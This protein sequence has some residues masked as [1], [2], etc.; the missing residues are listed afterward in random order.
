MEQVQLQYSPTESYED[1]GA[2]FSE[3]KKQA[4]KIRFTDISESQVNEWVDNG[5]LY[6]FQLYNKDYA[7]GAHGRKNLHTLYWENLFTD[8]N[9]SNLVLKLNGQ[10]ELFCRPQSIKKPV[11]HKIGSKMLN[12]RDKSGM[13]I[14]E[15]IYRS[16][17]QFYNGK[18]KESELTTA[19]KQYMDQ[20]I[21]K[22]VTHEIIKDRR[23]TRQEYFF[24]LPL[25]L[26]ANA[27][28]N[29]YI[30][31]QVL[32][33]LKDNPD[34]NIIGIDRGERHLIY[35][36]LINQRGEI[37]KQKTFNIV[38]NYNYQAKLEQRERTRRGS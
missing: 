33:Y 31:E 37:L 18:K 20:V 30:N 23:Y 14:P 10:A 5:Q 12:R 27:D 7:E 9:L 11:S 1:I 29:E 26:N 13:P 28:G 21:V 16:L 8:E 38:N 22:D 2:F 15:N 17:Y 25:T 19:E 36:T 35:L 24:H 34:V 32:N 6:L 3:I 4:Y